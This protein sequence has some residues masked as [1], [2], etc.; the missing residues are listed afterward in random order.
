MTQFGTFQITGMEEAKK[1]LSKRLFQEVLKYTNQDL[2]K[3]ARTMIKEKIQEGYFIR[4]SD[5]NAAMKVKMGS[6]STEQILQVKSEKR[7]I[8]IFKLAG[9]QAV[10]TNLGVWIEVQKRKG[11]YFIRSA[12]ISTMKS[13]HKGVF[14]R[15]KGGSG[16]S[17]RVP[18]MPIHELYGPRITSLVDNAYM[19]DRI[20]GF[21][22]DNA[23]RIFNQKLK[24][25][26]GGMLG[27]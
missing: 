7:G 17:G 5:L 14:I 6:D 26:T 15:F 9:K 23:Q 2:A 13:G 12:F 20:N 1:L 27:Q 22:K 11:A 24:W 25:K 21:L 8:P 19:L 3:G 18:R 10:K 4:P 16:K